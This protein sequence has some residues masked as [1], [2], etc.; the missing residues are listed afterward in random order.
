M[1]ARRLTARYLAVPLLVAAGCQATDPAEVPV[2]LYRGGTLT[3]SEYDSWLLYKDAEDDPD[4]RRQRLQALA[5]A[6]TLA[7]AARE[8]GVEDLPAIRAAFL[9]L[10]SR[11]LEPRLKE[12]LRSAIELEPEAIDAA[13]AQRQHL[14]GVSKRV[15]IRNIFK[16]LPADPA[17][18]AGVRERMEQI[19]GELA[20]GAD[21]AE[22]AA[23]ESVSQSRW[24]GGL[25]GWI[26]PGDLDPAIEQV[27][28]RLRPGEL[29]P[30]VEATGGLHILRCDEIREASRPEP[31]EIRR[32]IESN[33][34]RG[35]LEQAWDKL[36]GDLLADVVID[37]DGAQLVS[38]PG[39]REI[40]RFGDGR[41]LNLAEVRA[42]LKLNRVRRDPADMTEE[43]FRGMVEGI[44]ARARIADHARQRGL[45]DEA[46]VAAKLRWGRSAILALEEIKARIQER[47]AAV[48]ED[49]IRARFDAD[50]GRFENPEQYRLAVI[51]IAVN[52]ST[53]RERYAAAERLAEDLA[54]GQVDFAD[55][56][57]RHSDHPSAARG[58]D[59]D[60]LN[61]QQIAALG[62][63][64]AR[65][66]SSLEP[67]ET[68]ELV[69][70]KEGLGDD[71]DLW[72]ARLLDVRPARPMTFAEAR[73]Q[74]ENEIGQEQVKKLRAEI[75]RELVEGLE[76]RMATELP[77]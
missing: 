41:G 4:K 74:V 45:A 34:R 35:L 24:R 58:G 49:Q 57:R 6:E 9:R 73:R 13:F 76:L 69:Q 71:S 38:A 62:P 28:L 61:R 25:T 27:A 10:E 53:I 33:L 11:L 18:A 63:I 60:W 50:P 2:A 12:H 64:V 5:I 1:A 20:A 67:G 43:R 48:G 23:R 40:V 29:G 42:L 55:A 30:V 39:D 68:S 56:A 75:E 54:A 32:R 14:F 70:Q 17:A 31:E 46:A 26:G 7:A 21:F 77:V 8:R 66:V 37:L 47:F 19:L 36:R 44:A 72:I 22:L 59:L 52:K 65:V 16:K 15:R 3:Q 51:A